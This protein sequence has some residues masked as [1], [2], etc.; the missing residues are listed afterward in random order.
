MSRGPVPV[1][2]A[3]QP[4]GSLSTYHGSVRPA[5]MPGGAVRGQG[6]SA[7]RGGM[8]SGESPRVSAASKAMHISQ[9]IVQPQVGFLLF[10][11]VLSLCMH[12]VTFQVCITVW[13]GSTVC[14]QFITGLRS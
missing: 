9:P 4:G 7:M 6:P 2:R 5:S 11:H 3:G 14:S 8:V 10:L 13:L 12:M 1:Q